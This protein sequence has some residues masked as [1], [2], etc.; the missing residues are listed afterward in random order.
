MKTP[1]TIPPCSCGAAGKLF[2]STTGLTTGVACTKCNKR[3]DWHCTVPGAI[4]EW[5]QKAKPR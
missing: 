1:V 3:T 4:Q 5:T 2:R